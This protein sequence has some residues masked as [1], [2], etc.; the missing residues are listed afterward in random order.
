[1]KVNPTI[2]SW[3][4]PTTNVDGTPITYALEYEVGLVA[5][6]NV[7]PLMVV[8]AQLQTGTGYEAPIG[9]LG[10]DYGTYEVVLRTFAK[11]DPE[12]VSDWSNPVEFAISE[13]IPNAPL[14]LRVA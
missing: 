12:R 2:L 4:G 8:P 6:G 10:L 11:D 5:D 3:K 1:M 14:E 9:G 13:Q 7:T